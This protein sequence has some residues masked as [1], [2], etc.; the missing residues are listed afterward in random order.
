MEIF[1][2]KKTMAEDPEIETKMNELQA[3]LNK[4]KLA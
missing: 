1:R 3:D 2:H 4:K